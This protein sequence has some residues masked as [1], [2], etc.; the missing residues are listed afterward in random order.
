MLPAAMASA[1]SGLISRLLTHPLDTAKARLQ[2]P[3]GNIYKGTFDVLLQ[4][5]RA[6]GALALYRGFGAIVVGGTPGTM[7]YLCSYD[8]F[9]DEMSRYSKQRE[10]ERKAS[11]PESA[12]HFSSGM[13]AEIIACIVY[14]PVDVIK[15][16][17]QVQRNSPV[18]LDGNI[19]SG[20]GN[21]GNGNHNQQY[22]GSL[23]AL[24]KIL[25]CEGLGGIYKGYAA[26][27]ASFGPYS[28]LYFV[29]YERMKDIS[30]SILGRDDENENKP[31]D[32]T[33][34]KNTNATLPFLHTIGCSA[35][36]GA[37]A[38]W[39]TSPLDMA[40]LRLQIQ[41]GQASSSMA[42]AL[43]TKT[44]TK[45]YSGMVECLADVYKQN[46]IRGFFRGA[47]ARVIHFVPA[48]TVM[49]TCYEHFQPFYSSMI[50]ST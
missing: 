28:A 7:A 13:L 25:K 49:M 2:A 14:V 4:T 41:R 38:S 50:S 37:A 33:T 18:K 15:E 44:K 31:D 12:I 39:L 30:R 6:E 46:G 16:R 3:T 26:T 1:T 19:I 36:A 11:I 34:N 45:N 10:E 43:T 21:S 8:Y 9:R 40:K 42:T 32:S 24:Q 48:T 22:K 20:S 5:S 17:L 27:L 35:T 47:G 29:F 23:D